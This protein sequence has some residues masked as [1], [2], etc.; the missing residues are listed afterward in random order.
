[1]LVFTLKRIFT[2]T[3]TYVTFP[4][5]N[6]LYD[7]HYCITYS[8]YSHYPSINVTYGHTQTVGHL[9]FCYTMYTMCVHGVTGDARF[10][11]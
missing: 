10:A 4:I 6:P 11:Q 2:N 7:I 3:L 1:M 8:T 5:V 9:V